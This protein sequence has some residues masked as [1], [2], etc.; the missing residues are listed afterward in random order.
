MLRKIVVC[1]QHFLPCLCVAGGDAVGSGPLILAVSQDI[2]FEICTFS[3]SAAQQSFFFHKD[4][5]FSREYKDK[6]Q[7]VDRIIFFGHSEGK[8]IFFSRRRNGLK[9]L[10]RLVSS[11]FPIVIPLW[12]IQPKSEDKPFPSAI[13]TNI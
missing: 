13:C 9:G 8:F 4:P 7:V 1:L 5:N 12:V 2:A 11:G 3:F 6:L 10:P